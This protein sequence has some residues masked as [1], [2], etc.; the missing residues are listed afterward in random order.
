MSEWLLAPEEIWSGVKENWGLYGVYGD[1]ADAVYTALAKA[2]LRHVFEEGQDMCP[3]ERETLPLFRK[4]ECPT[5]WQ[6]LRKEAG[7]E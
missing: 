2:Q 3:H 7:L 6:A 1:D 5:C 4:R